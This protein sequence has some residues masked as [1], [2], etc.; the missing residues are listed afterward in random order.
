MES[1]LTTPGDLDDLTTVCFGDGFLPCGEFLAY[2]RGQPIVLCAFIED[3][4]QV[5]VAAFGAEPRDGGETGSRRLG[6]S[7][8]GAGSA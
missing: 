5:A 7:P 3:P 4:A 6:R 1:V 2:F 8:E